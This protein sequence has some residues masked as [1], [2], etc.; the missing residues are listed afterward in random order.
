MEKIDCFYYINLDHRVDRKEQMEAE[1]E[2]VGIPK[3][4]VVRIPGIYTK[5]FGILGCAL[6]HIKTL[7]TFLDS[8]YKNC[9]VCEDDFMFHLDINYIKYLLKMFFQKN[10]PYDI[11]MLSGNVK[12]E[13]DTS[14]HFLKKIKEAQTTSSYVITREFAFHLLENLREGAKL[15]KEYKEATSETKHEY[16]LD[17]YWQKLQPQSRWYILSPKIG[18]QRESYSDI[19]EHMTNYKV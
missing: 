8:T 17:I 16:C 6:S 1:F 2:K 5:G 3:E 9:L 13:E 7:E 12:Q 15:L 18:I 14:F 11:V 4:K 10:I 19:A